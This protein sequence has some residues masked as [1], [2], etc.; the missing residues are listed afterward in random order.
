[1]PNHQFDLDISRNQTDTPGP[2]SAAPISRLQ[3]DIWDALLRH[4]M[5]YV[6]EYQSVWDYLRRVT[7][8]GDR[9]GWF[10]AADGRLTYTFPDMDGA[11]RLSAA[12][13]HHWMRRAAA[14][15]RKTLDGIAEQSDARIDGGIDAL[16]DLLRNP[17]ELFV[18]VRGE[19]WLLRANGELELVGD[20]TI[21]AWSE[22]DGDERAAVE[23]VRERNLC[24]CRMCVQM[25]PDPQWEESWR[26]S[27]ESDDI[28]ERREAR[29]FILHSTNPSTE[30]IVA[31]AKG[32]GRAG[33]Y[34][35][36]RA[37]NALGRRLPGER[38]DELTDAVVDHD[39]DTVRASLVAC[40]AGMVLEPQR[41][42]DVLVEMFDLPSPVAETAV[43]FL[44]YG[45]LPDASRSGIAEALE[46]RVGES[47]DL[48]YAIALTLYNIYRKND[49]PPSVVKDTLQRL[50]QQSGEAADVADRALQWFDR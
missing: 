30:T 37:M 50:S 29:W 4:S 34:R 23:R 16:A 6:G 39:D 5:R 14:A 33:L 38:V 13:S 26:E 9:E 27:L 40:I 42:V 15:I 47:D 10:G 18:E 32:T 43:E 1:M 11:A 22:L 3:R 49:Y 45:E 35:H 17:D 21:L 8:E 44:G 24:G 19:P 36:L 46:S 25:R 48:N 20:E 12:A 41:R 7:T 31:A 28:E 2:F